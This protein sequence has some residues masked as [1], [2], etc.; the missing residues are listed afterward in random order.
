MLKPALIALAL[1]TSGAACAQRVPLPLQ[2][3]NTHF[4]VFH[5]AGPN[6]ARAA[7]LRNAAIV[8]QKLYRDL[9]A[10]GKI[11]AGGHMSG[12]PVLGMSVFAPG[13]DVVQMRATLENDPAVKAGIVAIEFREW[14]LQM[15]RLASADTPKAP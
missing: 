11:I 5:R 10:E 9:A 6:F 2:S 1:L 12:E 3:T 7:E 13:V 8:H 15:G 14:Q 4:V